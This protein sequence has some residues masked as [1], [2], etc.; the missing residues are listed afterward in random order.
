MSLTSYVRMLKWGRKP[1]SRRTS[2]GF[3]ERE[4]ET[5]HSHA[6]FGKGWWKYTIFDPTIYR[7]PEKWTR[8]TKVL[9]SPLRRLVDVIK[10]N[11]VG[12]EYEKSVVFELKDDRPK[13][14]LDREI[15]CSKQFQAQS[16]CL[17]Y[18]Y[19]S[20]HLS[21]DQRMKTNGHRYMKS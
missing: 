7:P 13:V 17:G 15:T 16:L 8:K 5:W 18:V 11:V 14:G 3:W 2:K 4:G 9:S 1:G 20:Q 12:S 10:Y 19:L 6:S 21:N